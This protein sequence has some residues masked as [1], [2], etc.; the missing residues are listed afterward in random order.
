MNHTPDHIDND[1]G[2][3]ASKN[4]RW[5]SRQEQIRQS[6][7]SNK[8]RKSNAPQRSKPIKGRLWNR[9]SSDGK[10]EEWVEYPSSN[11]AARK[12]DL[13]QGNICACLNG[14]QKQTG[15]Y[16][17]VRD[18]DAAEPELLPGEEWRDV[19]AA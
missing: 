10:E 19:V 1:R 8:D 4:L 9:N 5:A 15:G 14:R 18:E 11:A 17:F 3:N 6:Y 7:E 2:N 16:E 13:D 12:L